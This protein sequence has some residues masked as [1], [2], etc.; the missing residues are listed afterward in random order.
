M[1][2]KCV[3]RAMDN[4]RLLLSSC[5]A[6]MDDIVKAV[7]Y[8][9]DAQDVNQVYREYFTKGQEPARRTANPAGPRRAFG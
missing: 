2:A 8:L 9:R 5:G 7:V 6:T 1:D 3:K 4:I